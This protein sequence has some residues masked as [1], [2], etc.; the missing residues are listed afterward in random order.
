M[1]KRSLSEQLRLIIYSLAIIGIITVIAIF[2]SKGL[3]AHLINGVNKNYNILVSVFMFVVICWL[4]YKKC[5]KNI[6]DFAEVKF[7]A[8]TTL[9]MFL[10]QILISNYYPAVFGISG[11]DIGIAK[12]TWK[13]IMGLVPIVFSVVL[14]QHFWC[15][16]QEQLDKG[17]FNN[18]IYPTL[19][20]AQG[21][22]YTFLGVSVI[23]FTYNSSYSDVNSLLAGLKMAFLT[24]VI[25]LL[26]SI[27]AK[28]H[29]NRS[30][31]EWVKENPNLELNRPTVTEEDIYNLLLAQNYMTN[32][33]QQYIEDIRFYSQNQQEVMDRFAKTIDRT[34]ANHMENTYEFQKQ[35]MEKNL[36]EVS[37]SMISNVNK[38]FFNMTTSVD[39]VK[40][41]CVD[42]NKNLLDFNS[43]IK[44]S[45]DTFAQKLQTTD[46]E[47]DKIND[48]V[49]KLNSTCFTCSDDITRSIKQAS[50][51]IGNFITALKSDS[52]QLLTEQK[53]SHRQL[54][55]S[56]KAVDDL[57]AQNNAVIA[58]RFID[59]D[60]TVVNNLKIN[61]D[62]LQG[63]ILA[64]ND[65][66]SRYV[67]NIE[68]TAGAIRSY[69]EE[70]KACIA[71]YKDNTDKMLSSLNNACRNLAESTEQYSSAQA[72]VAKDIQKIK[73][74]VAITQNY[75]QIL[76]RTK[77]E[78]DEAKQEI[79]NHYKVIDKFI[80]DRNAEFNTKMENAY[81][82]HADNLNGLLNASLTI[83]SDVLKAAQDNYMSNLAKMENE[84]EDLRKEI[85][86]S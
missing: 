9:I 67:H 39:A 20:V 59:L 22:F 75:S 19:M 69:N 80:Q 31:K 14:C 1:D 28:L 73:E 36:R 41:T 34:I 10:V 61:S 40:R 47:L 84:I 33:I 16:L 42:I 66:T 45:F 62:K 65:I 23:L 79:I 12:N 25:G 63:Y 53:E 76:P 11:S 26:F 64:F 48:S 17:E 27:A 46:A 55:A 18:S 71:E 2:L 68:D 83:I 13:F 29:I 8:G 74:L 21:T 15:K 60:N 49:R 77:L 51:T 38:V 7:L 86:I 6:I 43:N 37:E 44:S 85:R 5:I 35:C 58:Q 3:I 56:I 70:A 82:T 57:F 78:I 4:L 24:S 30:Q 32:K 81:L 54:T 50:S 52:Y 72:T